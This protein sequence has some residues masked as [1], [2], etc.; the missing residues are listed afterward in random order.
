M[1]DILIIDDDENFREI[2]GLVLEENG[3]RVREA[4]NVEEAYAILIAGERFDLILC[5]LCMPY[6]SGPRQQ[7]YKY[8]HEVGYKTAK[9]LASV[10]PESTVIVLS[11]LP[12]SAMNRLAN[13]LDPIQAFSKPTNSK[14]LLALLDDTAIVQ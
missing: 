13:L 6:T 14:D 1:Q 10:L 3:Y 4:S 5:D 9:E 12:P 11:S 7:E 2:A 8:T